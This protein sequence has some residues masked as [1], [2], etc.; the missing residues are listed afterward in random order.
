MSNLNPEP[1]IL[2]T[3]DEQ[4]R[5]GTSTSYG[6]DEQDAYNRFINSDRFLQGMK[7]ESMGLDPDYRRRRDEMASATPNLT[8]TS[9]SQYYGQANPYSMNNNIFNM[10]N[11]PLS[12]LPERQGTPTAFTSALNQ[13]QMS[14]ADILASLRSSAEL[15][16]PSTSRNVNMGLVQ[17]GASPFDASGQ[18]QNQTSA[19][20]QGGGGG[21]RFAGPM[22][23]FAMNF[24]GQNF[25]EQTV[26]ERP[27]GFSF[28]D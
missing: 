21:Y 6:I 10:Q 19:P 12:S 22:G 27:P 9:P 14:P 20:F 5:E 8:P 28:G 24:P 26:P 23:N 1:Y 2:K 17:Q 3:I 13:A 11:L 7:A 4:G 15:P 16:P 18:I 25:I